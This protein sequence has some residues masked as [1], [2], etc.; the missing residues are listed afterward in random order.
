FRQ[1]WD[2]DGRE[3]SNFHCYHVLEQPPSEWSGGVGR[4]TPEILRQHL[5]SPDADSCIFLCGP[6]AMVDSLEV[7]LKELGYPEQSIILP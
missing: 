4:I 1:E 6:P 3:H 7:T 2:R 5:P